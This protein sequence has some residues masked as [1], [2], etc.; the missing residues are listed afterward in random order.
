[1]SEEQKEKIESGNGTFFESLRRNFKQIREDR[2]IAIA[3]DGELAFKRQ[4]EDIEHNL[5]KMRRERD[6]MLDL[7][8]DHA[9]S[10]KLA[11]DFNAK[12]FAVNHIRLGIKI[13]EEEIRL[14]I[15]KRAYLSLFGEA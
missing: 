9:Q 1:M 14:D 5:K 3:E 4:V 6:N 11:S 2:A 8:P 15:A 7:S 12:E 13:R 10:L